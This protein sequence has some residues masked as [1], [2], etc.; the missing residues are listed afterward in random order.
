MAA[1]LPP[2]DPSRPMAANQ[3]FLYSGDRY[4]RGDPFPNP[5][6][7]VPLLKLKQLYQIRKIT[8][9]EDVSRK[10]KLR[11]EDKSV[12]ERATG[13]QGVELPT[14]KP[15]QSEAEKAAE[16]LD[17]A[18]DKLAKASTKDALLKKASGL[19]GV[20]KDLTKVQIAAALIKAGR[21]DGGDS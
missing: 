13:S 3:N 20:T 15:E 4:L 16:E 12:A 21:A 7:E 19:A 2:F 17:A 10:A 6:I 11:P 9:A 1:N 18:A 14:L 8:Y 5:D